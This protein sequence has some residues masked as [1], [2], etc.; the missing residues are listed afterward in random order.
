[1]IFTVVASGESARHWVR[2]GICIGSNDVNKWGQEVDYL[3]LANHPGKFKE[4]LTTIKKSKANVLTTSKK[5]WGKIF[6]SCEQ[7]TRVTSFNQRIVNGFIYT[8]STT[9]I[10]C[11]SLGIKLGAKD[12]ILWGVDMINHR[13]WSK[14]T[15]QGNREIA[16]YLR[17]FD[18]CQKIGV[19]LYLGANNTAFDSILPLYHD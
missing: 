5:Q 4:R 11:I 3:I 9:P 1:M 16:I 8:S 14:G 10:M 17:F 6:P 13:V 2:R 15:K 7:I 18:A 12:I 19:K